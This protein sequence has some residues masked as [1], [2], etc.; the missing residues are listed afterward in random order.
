MTEAEPTGDEP[1]EK[2]PRPGLLAVL[3]GHRTA[4][5][6][7]AAVVALLVLGTGS[8]LA[9]V[10]VASAPPPAPVPEIEPTPTV[11]PLPGSAPAPFALRSCSVGSEAAADALQQ[12]HAAV[13]RLDGA[14][15]E[16]LYGSRPDEGVPVGGVMKLLTA[17][18]VVAKMDLGT[19]VPTS[20]VAGSVPGSIVLIGRGDATLSRLPAGQDGFYPG[21]PRVSDLAEEVVAAWAQSSPGQEITHLIVDTQAMSDDWVSSWPSSARRDGLVPRMA[22]LMVDGDRDDPTKQVSPR[23]NDPVAR[24]TEAF[25]AALRAADPGGDLVAEDLQ[26]SSGIS[27][28]GGLLGE[29]ESRPVGELLELMLRTDDHTLAEMLARTLALRAGQE[30]SYASVRGVVPSGLTELGLDTGGITVADGSGLSGADRVPMSTLAQLLGLI[31]DGEDGLGVVRDAL[32]VGG[33]PGPIAGWFE[34]SDAV[35]KVAGKTGRISTA[36]SM[37]GIVEAA[38]GALLAFAVTGSREGIGS[39]AWDAMDALVTGFYECGSNLAAV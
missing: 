28:G 5:T 2:A 37:A 4:V 6:V 24:A 36:V 17:A 38:D 33:E 23:S 32:P 15:S 19:T 21:A 39:G 26:I 1:A 8:L 9:G 11:R 14:G 18:A 22:A 3:R 25:V 35:G 30:G 20:V 31:Q 16:L 29:V 12:L 27:S 7:V 13:L 10:A 34:G